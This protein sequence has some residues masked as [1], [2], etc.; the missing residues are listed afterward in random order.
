MIMV[1]IDRVA[2]GLKELPQSATGF[3]PLAINRF[4]CVKYEEQN[5][6]LLLPHTGLSS[7]GCRVVCSKSHAYK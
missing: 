6:M 1:I 4:A 3:L 7:S 5:L 2:S